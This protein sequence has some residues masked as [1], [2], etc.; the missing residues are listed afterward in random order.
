MEVYPHLVGEWERG[1]NSVDG[2]RAHHDKGN[3]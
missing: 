1:R 2:G 3:G